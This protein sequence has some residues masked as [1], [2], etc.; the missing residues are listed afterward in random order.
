MEIGC[1]SPVSNAMNHDRRSV[2][3]MI[4]PLEIDPETP[5]E[6]NVQRHIRSKLRLLALRLDLD[7]EL[8]SVD[9]LIELDKRLIGLL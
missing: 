1:L 6:Y 3:R 8:A 4:S 5:K 2:F 9:S 7:Q